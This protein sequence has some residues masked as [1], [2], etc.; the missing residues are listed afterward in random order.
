MSLPPLPAKAAETRPGGITV[1]AAY[2]GY[3]RVLGEYGTNSGDVRAEFIWM[4]PEVGDSGAFGGDD[5][6]GGYMPLAVSTPDPIA[7]AG[8][9]GLS[10]VHANHLGV[11]LRYS[12]AA[13]Q[14]LSV[15]SSYP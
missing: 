15:T 14:T 3:D 4:S 12:D 6:L 13:G 8:A 10:W 5:G 9:T 11:P 1:S 2:D 7:S